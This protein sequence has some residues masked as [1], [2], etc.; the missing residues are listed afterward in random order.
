MSF[1]MQGSSVFPSKNYYTRIFNPSNDYCLHE[2]KITETQSKLNN[3]D[4]D[5]VDNL[6]KALCFIS[7]TDEDNEDCKV[8][9]HYMYYWIGSILLKMS[10]EENSFS[11]LIEILNNGLKDIS[12]TNKCKCEFFKN[13]N[14]NF[15]KMKIVYDYCLDHET[16]RQTLNLNNNLCDSVFKAYLEESVS[17]YENVYGNCNSDKPEPYCDELR[18]HVP[19]CFNSKLSNLKCN[20]GDTSEQ[21]GLFILSSDLIVERRTTKNMSTFNFSHIF[22]SVTIPLVGVVFICFFLYKFTPLVP[23]I[24]MHLLRKKSIRRNLD[25][26]NIQD[27]RED[28][29][30]KGKSNLESKQLNVVYHPGRNSLY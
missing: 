4:E 17:T 13:N 11:N 19:D 18:K 7:F 10:K 14:K 1:T 20:I 30:E 16:I 12:G 15:K 3:Y 29:Y 6:L 2:E 28:M 9:C 23:W 8:K 21:N 27:I 25:D 24:K 22:M 26:I 5:N